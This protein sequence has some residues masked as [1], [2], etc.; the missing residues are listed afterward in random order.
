M[1]GKETGNRKQEID[2]QHHI[3]HITNQGND[4]ERRI[5]GG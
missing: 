5:T 2:R 1:Y 4:N 3:I